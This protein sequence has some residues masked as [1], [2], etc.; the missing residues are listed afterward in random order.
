MLAPDPREEKLPR[1]AQAALSA[2]RNEN[3][4]LQD[5]L[6]EKS[7][8][9]SDTFIA[10]TLLMKEIGLGD[11]PR[12]RFKLTETAQFDVV[13]DRHHSPGGPFLSVSSRWE[14]IGIVPQSSNVVRIREGR[15]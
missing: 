2:L 5:A 7:P 12:I 6:K 14:T 8:H 11:S 10:E 1:W 15:Y 9:E 4:L 13:I 3:N